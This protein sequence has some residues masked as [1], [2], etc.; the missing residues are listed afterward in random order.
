MH[1]SMLFEFSV[2]IF[3][4]KFMPALSFLSRLLQLSL[5]QFKRLDVY[6]SGTEVHTFAKQLYKGNA[7]CVT[8]SRMLTLFILTQMLLAF[9]V[10]LLILYAYNNHQ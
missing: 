10:L 2:Q 8:C 6:R 5:R 1:A 4:S 7:I 9:L 3:Y